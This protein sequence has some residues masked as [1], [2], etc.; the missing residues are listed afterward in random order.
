VQ[1]GPPSNQK[2]GRL[3]SGFILSHKYEH[4]FSIM[5]KATYVFSLILAVGAITTQAADWPQWRGPNRDGISK[6]TGLLKDWP[7]NGPTLLWHQ[8][9]I[10]SGHSTP[11]IVGERIYLVS[12]KGVED[13]FVH[14]LEVKD[15]TQAWSTRIGKVGANEGPQY[16]GSRSTPTVDGD[17]L[18]ALG[19]D[20]DLACLETKTGKLRWQKNLRTE[21]GGK[22]GNWAFSES[23][24]IDGDVLVCTP[25]GTDATM[26][27]VNKKSG[28]VIWKSAFKEGDL[29]GY[30]SPIVVEV[31]GFKQ[32]VQ[33][34]QKALVG[35]DAK[36]GKPLWR[37]EKTAQ[38]SA[39]NIPTPVADKEYIYSASGRT[40]GGLVKLKV[41]EGAVEAE[42]VYFSP[43]LPLS[44]GGSVKVG[45]FHYGTG[46]QSMMCVE[47]AT[48]NLKWEDPAIGPAS[49]LYADGRLYLHGE[50]GEVALIEAT[51]EA[52]RV[53][54]RFL[55]SDQPKR[56]NQMDKS[57]TYPVVANGR[58]YIR[59][60]NSLWCYDVKSK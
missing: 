60:M 47:F 5:N 25:G 34:V 39:A 50:N 20:G 17:L 37:Y 36:T 7:A 42:Q 31:G 55:P 13:E 16:P 4:H 1:I 2:E 10:G 6:E 43:K 28:D 54:G 48:G 18:Y 59:D 57:W 9:E 3:V 49:I 14:A 45:D 23:V 51:P 41:N 19:S 40:G 21:F 46:R 56:A 24:L 53:K 58:L 15:G 26:L 11:S 52:Y 33:F 27:A 30:A 22:P 35:V 8:K 29:A 38:G 44:I 32:Y 12:N